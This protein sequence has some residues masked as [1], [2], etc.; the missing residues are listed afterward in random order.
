MK[1]YL[2]HSIVCFLSA[3]F[4]WVI[5]GLLS[6]TPSYQSISWLLSDSVTHNIQFKHNTHDDKIVILKIDDKTLD[7]LR[8]SDLGLLSIDKGFYAEVLTKLFED[9][10]VWTVWIDIVFANPSI[11]WEQ[12]D[13]KLQKALE[14]YHE[15]VVIASRSDINP[16]PLCLYSWVRHGAVD[17]PNQDIIRTFELYYEDYKLGEVCQWFEIHPE[18]LSSIKSLSY[19]LFDI[20]I[21]MLSPLRQDEFFQKRD[22]FFEAWGGYIGYFSNGKENEETF[23]FRSYSLIDIYEGKDIDLRD[24][25]ILIGEVWTLIHDSHFTP[26][27]RHV[28]MP[29][30]EINAHIIETLRQWKFLKD[31]AWIYVWLIAFFVAVYLWYIVLSQRLIVTFFWY[32]SVV[33][34][35]LI[36]S[37]RSFA[38]HDAIVPMVSLIL[39][40][41]LYYIILYLYRYI[42]LEKEK[43][44]LKK[45][46][47]LYVAPDVVEEISQNPHSVILEW[48]ERDMT[49]FFSD[50]VS[51][52]SISET[53]DAQI[54]L[55]LLNEYFR[56]MTAIIHRNKGTLDKYIWDA[57]MCFYGAPVELSDHAY[58]ACKTALEQQAR[59]T[60]LRESWK[61]LWLPDI[62][63]RIGIHSGW[64]IHGNIGSNDTRVNYTVI[65]DNV[66]LASRLEAICK[67]YSVSICVS[68]EVF[69]RQKQNF[70]MRELDMIQV[71]WKQQAIKIYE[72]VWEKGNTL[73]DADI[74][75]YQIYIEGLKAYREG[76]YQRAQ[77][78]WKT[79]VWDATS[80]YMSNRCTELIN[81]VSSLKDGVFVMNHK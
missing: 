12:D 25:I 8:R 56:E 19:Q 69:R 46:F 6:R 57:V 28:S 36:F 70:Y 16:H 45:Q 43:R 54:L 9:Y 21:P 2:Q 32:L 41:T 60:E 59:L 71:K 76:D 37:L 26:I 14:K 73:H 40:T 30:V 51:F 52:T 20:S 38:Y 49:I 48:E 62:R 23:W 3:L 4:V 7:A 33:I 27:Q 77:S 58:F 67:E 31:L 75:K 1:L 42:I 61:D 55:K 22:T 39:W 65:W 68:E 24:K 72:L 66:N 29:W 80:L 5:I 44:K 35:V 64:A 81:W 78:I 74:K 79:N 50:I 34:I 63:I 15:R 53:I 11:L 10:R 13:I 17:K 47:S 18:N